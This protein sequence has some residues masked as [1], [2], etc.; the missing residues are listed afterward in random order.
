MDNFITVNQT[1]KPQEN[2]SLPLNS[3]G[4][5][6]AVDIDSEKSS[7]LIQLE[8][9]HRELSF[10][11]MNFDPY[12]EERSEEIQGLLN[13]FKLTHIEDPFSVTNYLL[14]LLDQCEVQIK[15]IKED[16]RLH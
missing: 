8:Q 14:K 13:K 6:L 3:Q 7:D 4:S 9:Q 10:L 1:G 11:C 16:T 15:T 5:M 12:I 2:S